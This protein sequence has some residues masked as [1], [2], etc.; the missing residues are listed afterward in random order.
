MSRLPSDDDVKQHIK[1]AFNADAAGAPAPANADQSS[2]YAFTFF[3]RQKP[4]NGAV[5]VGTAAPG[6]SPL[7]ASPADLAALYAR[8]DLVEAA[9]SKTKRHIA[10]LMTLMTDIASG[11]APQPARTAKQP[12]RRL[13][14]LFFGCV[15]ALGVGWFLL[16]PTGH[17]VLGQA[18]A[19]IMG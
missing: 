16:S 3:H 2:V 14:W 10:E 19:L 8:F 12:L 1:D 11:F 18:I 9:N 15:A 6:D 4:N 17:V 5:Q 7:Y 13:Q